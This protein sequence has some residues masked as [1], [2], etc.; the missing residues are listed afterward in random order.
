ML[1]GAVHGYRGL[2]RELIGELR[3]RI[4]SEAIAGGGHRRLREADGV[5]NCRRFQPWNRNL[6]LEGLRLTWEAS[7][8][9]A[10]SR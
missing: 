5:L 2:V 1:V 3:R 4:E 6:T 8:S 7:R 10:S 9:L